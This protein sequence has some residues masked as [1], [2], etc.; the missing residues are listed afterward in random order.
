M[1][2]Y[3]FPEQRIEKSSADDL[4]GLKLRVPVHR[5]IAFESSCPRIAAVSSGGTI[6]AK[7]KGTCYVYVCLQNGR[8]HRLKI[9]VR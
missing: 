3:C 7:R 2:E 9:V 5:R 4:T 1:H 6:T 8:Y